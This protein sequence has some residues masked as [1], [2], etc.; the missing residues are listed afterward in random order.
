MALTDPLRLARLQDALAWL[1]LAVVLLAARW[2]ELWDTA[3]LRQ[4]DAWA[5]ALGA[6]LAVAA[7]ALVA[8]GDPRRGARLVVAAM[9][10]DLLGAAAVVAIALTADVTTS[11]R[12]D[13]VLAVV[14]VAL[15]IQAAFDGLMLLQA[16]QNRRGS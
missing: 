2:P 7:A 15:V 5:M 13:A 6:A 8:V 16:R 9:A 14:A 4:P 1:A 10:L 12:G 3:G 11:G